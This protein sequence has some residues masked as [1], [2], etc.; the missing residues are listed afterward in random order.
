MPHDIIDNRDQKLVDHINRILGTTDSARFAVGYFF[1]SG[2]E[3]IQANLAGVQKLRLLIG[4]TSSRETIEQISEGYKRLELVEA[5]EERERFLKKA[6]QKQ[7]SESTAGNL[8]RT[9]E[10]M[11]QTDGAEALVRTLIRLIEEKRLEVKVYTKGRLHAKAY[12]FD[13]KEGLYE[14]GIAVVGSSN[15]TLSG[16]THNTELNVVVHGNDNHERLGKWFDDLWAEAQDFEAHL[17][18]ELR[19]S[20]A[21][22]LATPYDI[23]MKTL[24]ALVADRLEEGDR[25]E[26]LWDD[27]ITRSLADFQKVAVKQAI[28]MIR[29][30]GGAFISDV[31]GLGKSY[32]GAGI[33]KHFERT[34][35]AKP[36]II[37]PKPLEAMWDD[38]NEEFDLNARILPMSLLRAGDGEQP[39]NILDHKKYKDRD[40]VLIDESHNFR[41]H[42]SQRYEILQDYLAKGGRKVCLLTATPRN[43]SARDV[44]HQI[45]LFHQDDIT[46]L[47]IDPPN[48]KEYFKQIEQGGK[49]LQDLL[50]HLLIRRTRRHILR[51]YG[52]TEDTHQPMRELS[53]AKAKQYLDG[54]KRAYVMVAGEHQF[55]PRRELETLR[56]SIEDTYKGLYGKIRAYLGRPAA[57]RYSPRPGAEL[58]YARYG[59]WHYVKPAMRDRAPY[60]DLHRAGINLR[61]LIR[62]MLFKRFESSVHAFR[63]TLERL[64]RIHGLYLEALDRGFVPAG[65][66][67]QSLLYESDRYDATDLMDALAELS[68]TYDLADFDEAIERANDSEFGLGASVF[69]TSLEEAMEA[70]ERLEAGM[71]FTIEPMLNEGRRTVRT[72]ADGWTVV[73]S[74]RKLSAQFEHTVAVTRDG[75]RVLTLR[76]DEARLAA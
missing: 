20:W 71:V 35:G 27:E 50:V 45:K 24:Y 70:A 76:P 66:E 40:F 46:H 52:F 1:L 25:G 68:G 9:V 53:D 21:A 62:V 57:K 17:M 16:L 33:V 19:Q 69:T 28:Q 30:H 55:F 3:A 72:E 60:K 22:A 8:R 23:Y 73:T 31:V 10:L 61:G 49:R 11:D 56:Y 58:T 41:H 2:L 63:C 7:R 65:E 5:A 37:C 67:A 54:G 74:D 6:E 59:L 51:Y 12:I 39:E 14:K 34:Q 48:L 44:Y 15:L 4:N 38:Y 42:S 36:L 26:I 64:E 47:P 29:D 18:E 43:K 13:C 75:V 32:I